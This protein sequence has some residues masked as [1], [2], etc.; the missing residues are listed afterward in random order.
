MVGQV[1]THGLRRWD[2]AVS[3]EYPEYRPQPCRQSLDSG[4]R[5]RTYRARVVVRDDP[6]L[7]ALCARRL[8]LCLP[9]K[10]TGTSTRG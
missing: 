8:S 6:S 9:G 1:R 3:L 7:R 10:L 2:E 4:S 5:Y